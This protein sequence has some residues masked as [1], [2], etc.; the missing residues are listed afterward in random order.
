[1]Y[2]WSIL[3]CGCCDLVGCITFLHIFF[4]FY[5]E[6]GYFVWNIEVK[7]NVGSLTLKSTSQINI[8]WSDANAVKSLTVAY[9]EVLVPLL[10]DICQDLNR[11]PS[12]RNEP[13]P[14]HSKLKKKKKKW[15][16]ILTIIQF[17]RELIVL[18]YNR[19]TII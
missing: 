11:N 4:S 5:C 9:N 15:P 16:V 13:K 7:Q 3:S 6:V 17:Y 19:L 18:T 1:M 10:G 8:R 14:L 12:V 2:S